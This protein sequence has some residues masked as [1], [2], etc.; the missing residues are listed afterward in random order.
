[1]L[2][3]R[4]AQAGFSLIEVM[5]TISLM[6]LLVFMAA[7]TLSTYLEN[8]RVRGVA[9][10]FFAAAQ[11]AR[12]EAIRLNQ[13]VELVMTSDE[14]TAA[15]VATTNLS[16][17]AGNWIIRSSDGAAIPTYTFVQGKSIREGSGRSDGTT[18]VNLDAKVGGTAVSSVIFRSAGNTSLGAR[19]DVDFSSAKDTCTPTGAIRC[20]RVAVTASGQVKSCDP[21]AAAADSRA[22]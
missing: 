8:S 20:L 5:V 18:S 1:M 4:N 2:I 21:V 16:A 3:P 14:P 11:T 19:W 17:T 15:N 7:P 13:D 12:A 10:V 9:E 22:C 6:V